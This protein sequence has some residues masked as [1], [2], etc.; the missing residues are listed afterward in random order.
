M[1]AL[2]GMK[3]PAWRIRPNESVQI[4]S[5]NSGDKKD[6]CKAVDNSGN[7]FGHKMGEKL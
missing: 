4:G 1:A 7:N 2:S 6:R 5:S 3:A